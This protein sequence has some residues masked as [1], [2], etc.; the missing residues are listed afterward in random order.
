[1]NK[2]TSTKRQQKLL[3]ALETRLD[4][5]TEN[6]A[7]AQVAEK[8]I[9]MVKEIKELH[10]MLRSVREGD[11]VPENV[12]AQSTRIILM[13]GEEARAPAAEREQVS[14]ESTKNGL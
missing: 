13:W 12:N 1:M 7:V 9:D 6:L 4:A 11:K 8:G 3:A 5:L 10:T 14:H 2:R